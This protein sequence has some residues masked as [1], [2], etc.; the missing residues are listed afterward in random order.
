[1]AE[2]LVGDWHYSGTEQ[3][4]EVDVWI[5]FSA[6]KTFDMYQRI[7]TGAYWHTT[8]KYKLNENVLSG[9]Y[10]D[11]YPW[12]YEYSVKLYDATL[13]LT[14][15]GVENYSVS[16]KRENIPAQVREKSLEL[17]KSSEGFVPF[18]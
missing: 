5:A 7:G 16:Y 4:A 11:K 1:M 10:S 6:D 3:G 9:V 2:Q 18:L 8:G 12:K 17:T 13:V 14:A 15:E